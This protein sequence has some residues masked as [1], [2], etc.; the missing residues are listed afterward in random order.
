[1]IKLVKFFR[2]ALVV[3]LALYSAFIAGV[4][5]GNK[6]IEKGAESVLASDRKHR[7]R[8]SYRN[9]YDKD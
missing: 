8:V 2:D 6:L 4:M 5:F 3:I 1:M 7:S 9:Y